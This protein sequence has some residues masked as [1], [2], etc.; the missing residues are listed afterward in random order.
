VIAVIGRSGD[1][2]TPETVP[3]KMQIAPIRVK[4]SSKRKYVSRISKSGNPTGL[5]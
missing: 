5:D 2:E 1:P 3:F 4:E